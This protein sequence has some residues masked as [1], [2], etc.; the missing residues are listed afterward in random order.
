MAMPQK[1]VDLQRVI[2][3]EA[4]EIKKIEVEYQKVQ[5]GKRS[6][7]EKKS[8]NEMVFSELNMVSED[9]ATVYKLV[10]PILA[11]QDLAEAKTN[12]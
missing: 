1:L 4:A 12:V 7:A 8:E 9:A 6:L 2:E 11:K 10:G 5:V 3:A